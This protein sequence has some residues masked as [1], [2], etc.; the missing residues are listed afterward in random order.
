M[1][2]E[3]LHEYISGEYEDV[4]LI[5]QMPIGDAVVGWFRDQNKVKLAGHQI[6]LSDSSGTPLIEDVDYTLAREDSVL[7]AGEGIPINA[8]Y[9]LLN[10]AF[11]NIP[12]YL[13]G[14]IVGAY[15]DRPYRAVYETFTA[16]GA[17]TPSGT[18][19]ILFIMDTELNDVSVNVGPGTYNNQRLEIAAKGENLGTAYGNGIDSNLKNTGS[20]YLWLETSTGG[21]WVAI[22]GTITADVVGAVPVGH[23]TWSG[24]IDGPSPTGTIWAEG[25][26]LLIADYLSLYNVYGITWGGDGITTFGVPNLQGIYPGAVGTQ[27][28]GCTIYG[29]AGV[30]GDYEQDDVKP[31]DHT[32]TEHVHAMG[33]HSHRTGRV[34]KLQPEGRMDLYGIDDLGV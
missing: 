32:Q 17:Y 4:T 14:R 33:T 11:Y 3:N 34:D 23:A 28:I 10:P 18:M 15:T 16:D 19:D 9:M 25:Q 27:D 8:G 30:I 1:S 6:I 24:T 31:H 13:S 29:T 5:K 21:A 26:I 7:S 12:V 22:G 20:T 2:F